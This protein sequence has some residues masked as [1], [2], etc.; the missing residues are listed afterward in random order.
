MTENES[1]VLLLELVALAPTKRS[2]ALR[3]SRFHHPGLLHL[4]LEKSHEVQVDDPTLA[5]GLA[6]LAYQL[7][8]ELEEAGEVISRRDSYLARALS[9]QANAYRLERR[10]KAA[11]AAF[12]R[13][14]AHLKARPETY[15]R[16]FLCRGLGLLRWEQGSP[17]EGIGLLEHAAAC[18]VEMGN[19]HDVA[20]CHAVL[21]LLLLDGQQSTSARPYLRNAVKDLDASLQPG[22]AAKALLGAAICEAMAGQGPSA[23]S[24]IQR[25]WGL[26]RE[27]EQYPEDKIRL[28]WLEGQAQAALG[29]LEAALPLLLAARSGYLARQQWIEASFATADVVVALAHR[30]RYDEIPPIVEDLRAGLASGL[31]DW[32]ADLVIKPLREISDIVR[33]GDSLEVLEFGLRSLLA[34]V[35]QFHGATTKPFAFPG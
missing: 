1:S 8:H 11:A 28:H 32:Q 10:P 7:I 9:L 5:G 16:G 22:L 4:L 31:E 6:R 20:V 12:R 17:A 18:F 2:Y 29:D 34:F 35:L 26:S 3:K 15:E 27:V 25:S 19:T 21:G 33:T 13:A 24:L 14:S 23:T 30:D